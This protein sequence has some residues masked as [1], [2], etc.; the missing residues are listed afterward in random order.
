M[1][2]ICLRNG[3]EEVRDAISG[4]MICVGECVLDR[5]VDDREDSEM[6]YI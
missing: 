1:E 5:T 6:G 4:N 2:M 3:P